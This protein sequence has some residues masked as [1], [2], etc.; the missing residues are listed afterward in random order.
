MQKQLKYFWYF[1]EHLE[2]GKRMNKIWNA[3]VR[4]KFHQTLLS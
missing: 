3:I 4:I 1:Y 2:C